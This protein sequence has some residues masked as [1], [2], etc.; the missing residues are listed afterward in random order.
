MVVVL[1]A[2]ANVVIVTSAVRVV[3]VIAVAQL[4]GVDMIVFDVH[5]GASELVV[6]QKKMALGYH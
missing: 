3:A 6:A 2:P 1:V 4:F 5:A